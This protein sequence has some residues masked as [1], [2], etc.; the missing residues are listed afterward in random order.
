MTTLKERHLFPGGNTSKGFY[1]FYRY[2]LSQDDAKR[3]LCIKGGPGTGKS[4]LMKKNCCLFQQKR[5]YNRISSLFFRS[6]F[7]RWSFN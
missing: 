1:S 7:F 4:Q 3:I 6:E 2:V 5:I